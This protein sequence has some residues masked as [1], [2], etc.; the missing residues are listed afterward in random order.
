MIRPRN[1][2]WLAALAAIVGMAASPAAGKKD[3]PKP[4]VSFAKSWDAAV[5]EAKLLNLPIVVHSH[6]FY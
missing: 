4:T 2:A 6:G 3:R 5:Q 1:L